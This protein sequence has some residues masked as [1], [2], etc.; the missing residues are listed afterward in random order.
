MSKVDFYIKG[1]GKLM[2]GAM[3]SN[4]PEEKSLAIKAIQGFIDFSRDDLELTR[5]Q[6][7]KI[8]GYGNNAIRKIKRGDKK[9]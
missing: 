8:V 3:E 5:F 6:V 9:K 7:C 4:N 2:Y 1:I